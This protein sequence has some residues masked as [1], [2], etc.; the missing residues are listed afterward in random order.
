MTVDAALRALG[1][2]EADL[3]AQALRSLIDWPA[4]R[5]LGWDDKREVFAPIASDPVFGFAECATAGCAQVG[6]T[7][8]WGLCCG[9]VTR[10]HRSSPEASFEEFCRTEPPR[11]IKQGGAL[12]L[13]CRTS[14]HERPAHWQGLCGS[15][16]STMGQRGQDVAGYI[17]GD[18]EFA[19][20]V[21]RLS[22]GCCGVAVC[23]RWAA[24]RKPALCAAH[25]TSWVRTGQHSGQTL[26]A[27]NA[28]RR[29]LDYDGRTTVLRG[30]GERA[31]L[32]MLYG[33]WCRCLAERRTTPQVMQ[34]VVNLLWAQGSASLFDLAVDHIHDER[35]LFVVFTRDRISL[36]L[37]TPDSEAVKDDWDLRVFGR[38]GQGLHFG[39]IA[40]PWL[41]QA[42]KRWAR[43]RLDTAGEAGHLERIAQCLGTF[44]ESL[45][46]HRPD[47]GAHPALLGRDDVLA[48]CSDLA[49][50]EAAGRLSRHGRG[51]LLRGVAQFLREAR[52]MGLARPGGPLA[53][54]PDDVILQPHDQV[55]AQHGDPDDHPRAL[56][57]VVVDQLLA[58]A[59]LQL[60]E[61]NHGHD[62]RAMVEL[63]AEVGRRTGELC[64][65][66]WGCLVF[67]EILDET[68]R[69]R[70]APVLVH[71]MPKVGI[72]SYHLPISE[73]AAGTIRAQQARVRDRYPDTPTARLALFPATVMNPRGTKACSVDFFGRLFLRMWVDSLS[74][75][76]GP[77]GEPYQRSGVIIY[78][79]R[80]C[81]AQRH[82]DQGTPIEV[83]AALMGHRQLSTTQGYYR[84]TQ[85]R[86]RK[87]VDLLAKFQVD[88]A[89]DRSR[90]AI[91]RLLEAE[92]LR[93]AVGQVAVPFGICTN[94]TNVRAH[95][96]A[97]PFR[98]RCFGCAHFRSDPSF[99]PELRAHLARLLADRERLR[100]AMPELEEWARNGAIPS[101][102][103]IAAIRR[104]IE[105]CQGVL[106]E[107]AAAERTEIEE[108][109]AVLRRG[110][111]QLDTSVPVRFLGLIGQPSPTLFPNIG[112]DE[113]PG[114]ER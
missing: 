16:V 61:T 83:L 87:A 103:E 97:C 57:Q 22:F 42:V 4:L 18:G 41:K 7:N 101:A 23:E 8:R 77:G 69:T 51:A 93:D 92:H 113:Q 72:R 108:S 12:C 9:C 52:G 35:R 86:K 89:G 80:H 66:R 54:L 70:P 29:T 68:G 15:C 33:L 24:H 106:G 32:E 64:G 37:A 67:D 96:Q 47:R 43:E 99:L 10:W 26:A 107:L 85:R 14:G 81:Y 104:V 5:S 91:E 13:V 46:R 50:L 36:A 71:D 44:S 2:V 49:H 112:R 58:P 78:S 53:G 94:P 73:Q 109:I 79:W 17:N 88:R 28:R 76:V 62:A 20:A 40:Q 55:R 65:L 95:G 98:H 75:L 63:Q 3:D 27:W 59:A 111:A 74:E 110:R 21:P 25:Y 19:P 90:P 100:A 38:A 11:A 102:E 6:G 34:M 60:L 45:C 105:R 114:A 39:Q 48:F 31:Q 1:L 30:L 82:A 84:I 56:P